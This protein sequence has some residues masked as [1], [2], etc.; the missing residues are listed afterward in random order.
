MAANAPMIRYR[1]ET[2]AA[3]EQHQ[4]MLRA[5]VT[6][7]HMV[8]GNIATF[9]VA[10]SGD[11]TP[12]T[13]GLDGRI[14]SRNNDN[15]QSQC[16]LVEWHDKP[17]Q[18]GF[19]VFESQGDQR[20][21]SQMSCVG[22]MNRKIDSDI[23][24]SSGLG[25]ATLGDSTATT[26][27]AN[28]ILSHQAELGEND[29]PV[30]EEDKMFCALTPKAF[31]L[32]K[33]VKEFGSG[34]YVDVKPFNGPAR[35]M[36]RWAG[37]NFLMSTRLTGMGTSS[38]TCYMWHKDAIGHAI[39]NGHPDLDGDYNREDDY[40]WT[41]CTGFFGSKLLQNTGIRKLLHNDA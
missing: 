27:T 38:A 5:T 35:R 11:A 12:V 24:G 30:D 17:V 22:V 31:G 7:E 23:L 3:F 6:T 16:T 9:L 15:T 34:D 25:A 21:I 10:G 4:S 20:R 32:L 8:D 14:P 33:Q 37:I 2:I 36:Y 1:D 19:N 18:T 39:A 29:V 26:L 41:R 28:W 13:R 40:Y